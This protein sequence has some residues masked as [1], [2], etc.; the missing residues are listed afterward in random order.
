MADDGGRVEAP[1]RAESEGARH[2][3]LAAPDN[4]FTLDLDPATYRS[5]IRAMIDERIREGPEHAEARE[6]LFDLMERFT[7]DAIENGAIQAFL[8]SG[9]IGE[10][11]VAA[12][13]MCTLAPTPEPPV[14]HDVASGL[15]RAAGRG[16][17]NH[18]DI[19]QVELPAG[20]AVRTRGRRTG[21]VPVGS[22]GSPI[23]VESLQ[24]V[25]AVPGRD[26]L[27]LLNFS[28]PDIMLSDTYVELFDAMAATLSWEY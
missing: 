17:Q 13:L 27:L 26:A 2:F 25:L 5:N 14:L 8:L 21:E 22:A 23:E 15:R 9:V 3:R 6:E 19:V 1:S 10:R 11:P 18:H 24:Y 12:S 4:W 7:S 20:P 16:T 28:T